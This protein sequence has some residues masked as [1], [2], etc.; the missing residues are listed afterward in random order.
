VFHDWDYDPATGLL[1][2]VVGN[3]APGA[4]GGLVATIQCYRVAP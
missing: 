1:C 2:H 3:T 4:G